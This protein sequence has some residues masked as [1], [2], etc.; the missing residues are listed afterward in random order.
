MP[1]HELFSRHY[2]VE[3]EQMVDVAQ[4]ALAT[5]PN[6][7]TQRV[8][9]S[10]GNI[11]FRTMAS[12]TSW[13]ENMEVAIEPGSTGGSV[14]RVRGEPRAGALSTPWGEEAHAAMIEQELFNAVA[15]ILR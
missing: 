13:G 9:A 12:L 8:D 1:K 4:Q 3:P 5:L 14:M 10:G 2:E 7:T 6:V 15:A 11:E